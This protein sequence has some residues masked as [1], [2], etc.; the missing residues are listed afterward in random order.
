MK[1]AVQPMAS[2]IRGMAAGDDIRVLY[3]AAMSVSGLARSSA[4]DIQSCRQK[5][6]QALSARSNDGFPYSAAEAA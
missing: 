1:W 2:A 6:K 5:G 4:A 3:H